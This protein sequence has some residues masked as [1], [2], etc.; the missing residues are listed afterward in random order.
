MDDKLKKDIDKLI[1]IKKVFHDNPKAI[2]K[3]ARMGVHQSTLDGKIESIHA[4]VQK[5]ETNDK[6]IDVPKKGLKNDL[7][8]ICEGGIAAIYSHAEAIGDKE[9]MASAKFKAYQLVRLKKDE[10]KKISADFLKKA[11]H[12]GALLK[13]HGFSAADLTEWENKHDAFVSDA[14]EPVEAKER[15]KTPL[16]L[17]KTE[18]ADTLRWLKDDVD[19]TAIGYKRKD[20]AFYKLYVSARKKSHE[21]ELK[22]EN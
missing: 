12:L 14:K 1:A 17:L 19:F 20:P 15:L 3:I 6:G 11:R 4:L 18:V 22:I 2:E 21:E 13:P 5:I 8:L 16:A 7:V 10:L 9:L